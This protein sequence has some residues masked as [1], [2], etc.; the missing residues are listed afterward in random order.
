MPPTLCSKNKTKKNTFKLNVIVTE[1]TAKL[2]GLTLFNIILF[3]FCV[4]VVVALKFVLRKTD[5]DHHP[6]IK[7]D[8][9]QFIR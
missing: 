1:Q 8:V 6:I 5:I 3:F 2:S 4:V 9:E 7:C